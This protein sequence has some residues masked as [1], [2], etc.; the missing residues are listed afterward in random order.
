MEFWH[1]RIWN[2]FQLISGTLTTS[3]CQ[4]GARLRPDDLDGQSNIQDT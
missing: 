4:T 3:K 1:D 2:H